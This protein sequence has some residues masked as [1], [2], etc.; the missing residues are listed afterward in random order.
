MSVLSVLVSK[1]VPPS[2]EI[3]MRA[4]RDKNLRKIK[5]E[6]LPTEIY[7]D[8]LTFH[9]VSLCITCMNRLYQLK[10]TLIQNILDNIEYPNVEVCLVNYNSGDGLDE[11]IRSQFSSYID[12]GILR[13]IYIDE[14]QSFHCSKAKNL[15]HY[16]ATGDIICNVDADNFTGKDFAFYINYLFNVHNKNSIFHFKKHPYWGTAGRIALTK[17]NFLKI[18]GY[19][20]DF[21]PTGHQDFN[22]IERARKNGLTYYNIEI[23]NFL[24]YISNSK[25][26]KTLNVDGNKPWKHYDEENKRIAAN[27]FSQGIY[28]A[29]ADINTTIELQI[30][31]RNAKV[32]YKPYQ[33]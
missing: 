13:Y 18:G 9:K 10:H 27:K 23:E 31:F 26:E 5:I 20:E 32:Q 4:F 15:S 28:Y 8:E 25:H 12:N 3:R 33:P 2:W 6:R 14:P 19:D 17:A 22:L 30:N 29:N 7:S 1:I 11:F 21:G 24:R 16:Y